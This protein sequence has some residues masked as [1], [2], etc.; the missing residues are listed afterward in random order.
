MGGDGKKGDRQVTT[1][2][3][4]CTSAR[5]TDRRGARPNFKTPDAPQTSTR[6][7]SITMAPIDDA[8]A[9]IKSRKHREHF[10]Y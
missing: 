10:S 2:C 9:A 8:I 1:Y 4:T 6:D 5:R 3:I 7:N